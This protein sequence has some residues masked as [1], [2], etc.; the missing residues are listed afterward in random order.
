MS[1]NLY[2]YVIINKRT[3]IFE[4]AQDGAPIFSLAL[5]ELKNK[6]LNEQPLRRNNN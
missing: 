6:F 3:T 2:Q 1:Y 5:K 4:L